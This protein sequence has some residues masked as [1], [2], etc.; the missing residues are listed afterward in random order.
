M[1]NTQLSTND[2]I[3]LCRAGFSKSDIINLTA[4]PTATEVAQPT[5]TA[6]A[7]ATAQP[8]ATEVATATAPAPPTAEA[9]SNLIYMTDE[10]LRTL[11][12][13]INAG[14]AGID[15]PPNYDISKVLGEHYTTLMVG[16][17]EE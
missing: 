1:K 17:K 15:I 16:E 5:P 3:A 10:Q 13:S 14:N 11:C 6:T 7:T 12:Q 4:Q 8:T 9:Q 2:I